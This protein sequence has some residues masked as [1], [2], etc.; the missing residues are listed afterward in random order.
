MGAVGS[1]GSSSELAAAAAAA[2]AAM[3]DFDAQMGGVVAVLR[4]RYR[5]E[6]APL[7]PN[8]AMAPF[9]SMLFSM[10]QVCPGLSPAAASRARP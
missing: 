4:V 7:V 8:A 2:Q 5:R 9:Q 1:V 3:A 6:H 10:R